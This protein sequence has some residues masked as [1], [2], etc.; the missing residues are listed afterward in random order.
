MM[1]TDAA[2]DAAQPARRIILCADDYGLAGGVNRAIRDLIIKRRLNATSVMI[3]GGALDRDAVAALVE[4]A[5]QSGARIGL[6]VTLSAPFSPQSLHFT[7]LEGGQFIPLG[8]LLLRA[9]TG[10]IDTDICRSE[11][12]AQLDRFHDAFGRAPDF[13]DGHQH[14]QLFPGIRDGFLD[15]VAAR[16]PSAWVR[17]CGAMPALRPS[18]RDAKAALIDRLSTG[19][20]RRAAAHRLAVNPAFTGAYDFSNRIPFAERS[21][22]AS[23]P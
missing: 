8:R 13:V 22:S 6:H 3:G 14:V 1:E 18:W 9:F 23:I 7:P 20:R 12:V 5:R 17:Q 11:I 4:A 19:F 16:A 2:R 15:A 21:L 10:R